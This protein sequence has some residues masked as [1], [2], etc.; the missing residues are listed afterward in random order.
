M[1]TPLVSLIIVCRNE[2][3]YIVSALES[4]VNQDYPS[5]CLEIILVDGFSA[6]GTLGFASA[7]LQNCGIKYKILNNPRKTLAS[8]WNM[9]I[10][11]ANG[12]FVCRIDAHGQLKSDYIQKG[13]EIWRRSDNKNLACV[14]GILENRGE[15]F[16]GKVAEDFFSSKF[17]VGNS[18]FR[19]SAKEGF[20]S[21]TAAMGIYRKDIFESVGY[22]DEG[23]DRNQD[24]ALHQGILAR[25]YKFFT[26]PSMVFIYQV[27][28]SLKSLLKKAYQDG[29]W[30]IFSGASYFRH[31]VP[32][33][34][35]VYL[36]SC[37]LIR[38]ICG[39]KKW[40]FYPLKLYSLI[41]LVFA[42]KDGKR[43]SKVVLPFLYFAYHI[44]YG[45]G[46]LLAFW[47]IL[48]IRLLKGADK[49]V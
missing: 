4:F 5:E 41:A 13:I 14:G 32:L 15:G 10:K 26:E 25:G 33:F 21:D 6:D 28:G 3:K 45:M 38:L 47:K 8:G 16:W 2:A 42:F 19:I 31:R 37:L 40:A 12:E 7:F 48:S 35:C 11:A 27:R 9:A 49:P 18:P 17:G 34:F 39:K 30:V 44:V 24:I 29:Y 43:A 20:Y 23:L 22:F 36:I 1:I 46:S